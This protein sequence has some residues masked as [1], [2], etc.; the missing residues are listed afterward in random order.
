VAH[1]R[2]GLQYSQNPLETKGTQEKEENGEEE[3]QGKWTFAVYLSNQL[4]DAESCHDAVPNSSCH[5]D[6]I[7]IH[8]NWNTVRGG[9]MSETAEREGDTERQTQRETERQRERREGRERAIT[10]P[11]VHLLL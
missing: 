10:L 2:D 9:E 7:P 1:F 3:G 11:R 6:T 4:R 5:I 8:N